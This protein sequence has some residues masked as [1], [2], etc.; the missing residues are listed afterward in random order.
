MADVEITTEHLNQ[1]AD[2][3]DQAAAG[4]GEAAMT[5]SDMKTNL[6]VSHGVASGPSNDAFTKA[7]RARRHAGIALQNASA[8][9]AEK[10]RTA[11]AAYTST[12]QQTSD[13]INKQ[14]RSY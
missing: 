12:D 8:A 2:K 9:L 7:E 4:S 6:W 5:A 11:A 1:L 10:L 3:Q 13:N 14:L